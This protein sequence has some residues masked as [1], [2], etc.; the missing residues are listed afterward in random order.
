MLRG[1]AQLATDPL[2]ASQQ[3]SLGGIDTVRGYFVNEVVRDSGFAV[4]SSTATPCSTCW[5]RERI[6]GPDDMSL[7]LVPFFD[8]GYGVNH[9]ATPRTWTAT[10]WPASAWACAGSGRRGCWRRSTGATASATATARPTTPCSVMSAPCRRSLICQNNA[11]GGMTI[12]WNLILFPVILC[13]AL[14]PAGSRAMTDAAAI[15]AAPRKRGPNT[16]AGKARSSMNALKHG[17]RARTFGILPEEDQAE[18]GQHLQ[19]LRQGYDPVDD[20]EE[21]LVTAIAVAMGH[22]IRADRTL[23]ETMVEIPPCGPGRSHGTDMA[24][25]THARSMST[26]IRYLTA[27]GMASR[28]APNVPSSSTA[29]PSATGCSCRWERMTVKAANQNDTN[30]SLP[31]L[32]R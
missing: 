15:P 8:Y 25:P 20:V 11:N 28:S 29:R 30:D 7:E 9:Q 18:W 22:E 1:Q 21:K 26:A 4:G 10:R 13:G 12:V 31:A 19:D 32:T 5:D 2:L 6:R 27:A 14:S 24:D 23:V 3:Y 16:P 17:L